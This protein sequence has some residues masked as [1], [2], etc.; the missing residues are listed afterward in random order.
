[1]QI[2]PLARRAPLAA[3]AA[4]ALP[5]AALA[6]DLT[7]DG[8]TQT[9]VAYGDFFQVSLTGAPN[10]LALVIADAT[11]G[12]V[13]ILGELVPIGLTP[14]LTSLYGT[15]LSPAG[16]SVVNFPLPINPALAGKTLFLV[17]V[18]G[19]ATDPNGLDFS[20]GCRV[21]IVPPVGAGA[22]QST[23]VGETVIFDGSDSADSDGMVPQGTSVFWELLSQPLGSTA[24]LEQPDTLFPSLTPDLPGDYVARIQV[25]AGGATTEAQATA[26]AYELNRSANID[27]IWTPVPLFNVSGDVQGPRIA[28]FSVNGAP[29]ALGAGGTFGP[30]AIAMTPGETFQEVL[31]EVVHTDGTIV[32]DRQTV[33]S[34]SP[35]LLTLPSQHSVAAHLEGPG[36]ALVADEAEGLFGD[37]DIASLLQAIGPQQIA[38]QEGPFG[39]TIFS[40]TVAFTGLTF[41]PDV[42]VTLTPGV[43]GVSGMVTLNNVQGFFNAS[44][45]IL[46]IGYGLSGDITSNPVVMSAT[47]S[48]DVDGGQID[49]NVSNIS[50]VR[51]NFNFDL[52]GFVGSVAELFIIEDFVKTEVENAVASA[53]STELA[54]AIEDILNEFVVSGNLFDLIE[55]D[56]QVDAPIA[57]VLHTAT[58][59]TILLDGSATVLS[60]EPEAP[61]ITTYRG[62]PSAPPVFGPSSP[63]G[64]GY[65]AALGASDDFLNQI[66][67]A[68]TGAGLLDGDPS[69]LLAELGGDEGGDPTELLTTDALGTLF[70]GAGFELFPSGT[71]ATLR[72]H[73]TMPPVVVT[74]PG[75]P[76]IGRVDIAD[77]ELVFGI[78]DGLGGSL[79]L[80]VVTLDGSAELDLTSEPD[81][82][83]VA[84]IG[85]LSVD[86]TVLRG[87][88]GSNLVI[89]QAG[90]DFL[91][92]LLLPTLT[93]AIGGIPLPSLEISGLGVDPLE[94]PLFGGNDEYVGF[95]GNLV[96]VP[97]AP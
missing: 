60:S 26:H 43:G 82:T 75:G 18:V 67:A 68:A 54:P 27:G 69:V 51:N 29:V 39:F 20:N 19:D 78:P 24:S 89:L 40:A 93:G 95:F 33:G 34:G 7:V 53:I 65:G 25:T 76:T 22:N 74:T 86:A 44:G 56:V 58:G 88:P 4:L 31:Y 10:A 62:T 28:S 72:S 5:S 2:P 73:A 17:G 49:A 14:S 63:G 80:L 52:D 91:K 70:P 8:G 57:D 11:P 87:F 37:L 84:N 97:T 21:D 85:E 96:I 50:V 94:V 36:L 64:L 90:L 12:P 71:V 42:Q 48:F 66:L 59:V 30:I 77:L 32:R 83:L 45:E 79:P 46:E 6:S 3:L 16:T 15:F 35:A 1:M 13:E 92:D 38:N 61:T 41:D 81:G 23:F 47:I 55:V 9:E